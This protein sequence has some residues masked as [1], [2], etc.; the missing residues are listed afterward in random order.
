[1]HSLFVAFELPDAL[2]VRLFELM[3]GVANAR[4]QRADQLHLTLRYVGAADSRLC[5]DII[6]ALSWL[7]FAAVSVQ[8]SGVGSFGEKR[9]GGGALWAGVAPHD[10]LA[11]L[12]RKLDFAM[13]RTGLPAEPRAYLPHITVARLPRSHGLTTDWLAAHAS[14]ASPPV[15]FNTLTLFDSVRTQQGSHYEPLA[16]WY[17]KARCE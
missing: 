11:A 4:W 13:V 12:H 16:R 10:A 15:T 3:S 17:C 14:L 9:S 2:A 1:M 7:D 8:L 6:S 5:D